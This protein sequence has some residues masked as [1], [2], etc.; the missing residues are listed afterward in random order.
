MPGQLLLTGGAARALAGALPFVGKQAAPVLLA[1][2]LLGV[3]R[4]FQPDSRMPIIVS[5]GA[6][7]MVFA[8]AQPFFLCLCLLLFPSFVSMPHDRAALSSELL[9]S[10]I[11]RQPPATS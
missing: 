11:S 1:T 7:L 3:I 10:S 9:A 8:V 4:Y 5:A 2:G 6:V